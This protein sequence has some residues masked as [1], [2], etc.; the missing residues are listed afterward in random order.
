MWEQIKQLRYRFLNIG[1]GVDD[2]YGNITF[3]ETR[4]A[5]DAGMAYLADDW[6]QQPIGTK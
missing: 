6:Y 1:A 4:A 2:G 5:F 3:I